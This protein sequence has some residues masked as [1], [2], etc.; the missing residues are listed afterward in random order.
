MKMRVLVCLAVLGLLAL[1]A[2]AQV[3]I[4]VG[5]ADDLRPSPFF[6]NPWSGSPNT[7]FIGNASNVDAGAIMIT[8]TSGSTIVVNSVLVTVPTWNGPAN[9]NLWGTNISLPNGD[10]LVLTQTSPY[11]F[12]TSDPGGIVDGTF[13]NST[14]NC[15]PS[16]AFAIAHAAGCA[17]IAPTI[18]LT[19]NGGAPGTFTD[20]GQVLDTGGFDFVNANPCPV[21]GDVPGACNESLQWRLIGTTGITNPGGN[22]PEPGSMV[23][24]ASGLIGLG[25]KTWKRFIG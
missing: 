6:P 4:S 21:R 9:T 8:N 7:I 25:R 22:T 18:V 15:D 3:S 23:L 2:M 5:Y 10:S 11:N 16:N 24:V 14:N 13:L 19:M 1:P 20:S 17:A 12:D